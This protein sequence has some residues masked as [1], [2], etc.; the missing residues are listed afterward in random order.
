MNKSLLAIAAA[1]VAATTMFATAAEAG[2]RVRLG[3][4]GPL[5]AFTAYGNSG[6]YE[7]KSCHKRA[8]RAARRQEKEPVRVSK[9]ASS[10]ASVASLETTAEP[11]PSKVAETENSTISVTG[12]KVAEAQIDAT[13]T[14]EPTQKVAVA[15]DPGCKKFF[16][17]VGMTL[18]VPCE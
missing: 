9:K 4:G 7:H 1:L 18:S 11:T 5:P 15:K 8:Y 14:D 13:K 17:S 2:F 16:P 6:S 10:T 3:F 12:A